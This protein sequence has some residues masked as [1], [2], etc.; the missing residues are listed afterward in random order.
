MILKFKIIS[1]LFILLLIISPLKSQES[2]TIAVLDLKSAGLS[3]LEAGVLTDR[4]RT[5]L[6][7]T[8]FFTVLEREVMNEILNEQGFQ[9]SGCTSNECAVEVGKLIG[10]LQMVTG[11]V[12]KIGRVF[13]LNIRLID[14]E[15]G[16]VLNTA[17]E[18]CQCAIEEVLTNSVNKVAQALTN[19]QFDIRNDENSKQNTTS[20]SYADREIEYAISLQSRGK[21]TESKTILERYLDV[22]NFILREKARANYILLDFS[23]NTIEDCNRFQ[24]LFPESKYNKEISHKLK[25]EEIKQVKS[26]KN[27]QELDA[28][29]QLLLN[30]INEPESRIREDAMAQFLLMGFSE[31]PSIEIIVFKKYFPNSAY[32]PKIENNLLN[33]KNV[34]NADTYS[35]KYVLQKKPSVVLSK[36]KNYC[37]VKLSRNTEIYENDYCLFLKMKVGIYLKTGY[38][39]IESIESDSAQVKIITDEDINPFDA[40]IF[41]KRYFQ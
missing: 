36:E 39:V 33:S 9:Q 22:N 6:F 30:Y 34:F 12:A 11:S 24:T 25:L 37:T 14:V 31:V 29:K 17:T 10:V 35:Y 26:T 41:L 4:L 5:E 7:R 19:K 1:I 38:G 3:E 27:K 2:I 8:N 20:D 18:D 32:L 28:A 23:E 40:V 21:T 16:K 13:T 15:T